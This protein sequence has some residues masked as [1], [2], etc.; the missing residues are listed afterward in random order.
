MQGKKNRQERARPEEAPSAVTVGET[1]F[2]N[3]AAMAVLATGLAFSLGV[4]FEWGPLN[5]VA[6]LTHW[7]WPWQDLG[8]FRIGLAVF[9][10]FLLI[11]WSLWGIKAD[12]SP[13]RAWLLA[14]ILAVANFA[15][16]ILSVAADPRGLQRRPTNCRLSRR[17]KLLH[18]CD[19][20]R[21]PCRVDEPFPSGGASSAFVHAPRRADPGLLCIPQAV[22]SRRGRVVQ[23]L[24]RGSWRKRGR[25][26]H[27]PVC[28][29][30]DFG[31][32]REATREC[33]VRFGSGADRVSR[34]WIRSTRSSRCS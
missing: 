3:N 23:R 31:S 25:S 34:N 12:L 2:S 20:H 4:I 11:L 28:R 5:G 13:L 7:E 16:E 1:G 26:G 30:V 8:T 17:H 18:R 19:G 10:P 32:P 21:R 24:C 14:G 29:I 9:A 15:G 6:S 27:V 33:L 22:R